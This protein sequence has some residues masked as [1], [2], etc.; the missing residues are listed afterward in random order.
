MSIT[1]FA[2]L[3]THITDTLDRTELAPYLDTLIQLGEGFLATEPRLMVREA[4]AT[5]TLTPS[6]GVVTLPTDFGGFREAWATTNPVAPLELV[7]PGVL[8]RDYPSTAASTP[9]V[10]SIVGTSMTIRPTTTADI[11]LIYYRKLTALSDGNTTNWL[12][13]AFPHVY[14]FA[15][16]AQA[17]TF[18]QNDQRVGVWATMLDAALDRIKAADALQRFGRART[19]VRGVT[20]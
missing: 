2:S 13:T 6:S 7:E 8:R 9:Y 20:P 18:I 12:L 17:E 16:L 5:A 4:E 14:L 15:S 11:E 1:D 19:R 3:K 10:C